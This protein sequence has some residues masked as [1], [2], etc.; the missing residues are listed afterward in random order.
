MD[1]ADDADRLQTLLYSAYDSDTVREMER[2]LLDD[3]VPL[4]RM[5]ASA[6]AH[7]T[8]TLLD[9][10]DLAVEDARVAL[11]VGAGDNGGD[12]LYAGAELANEGAHVTAIAVGRSLHEEA[13]GA[14]V[15][16]GGR[17]LVLDPAAEIPGCTTGFSAGE[18]GER[19]QAAVEYVQGSHVIIDAMTGIGVSGALRGIAGR[20]RF[21]LGIRWRTS[22]Q[23][24]PAEQRAF[25]RP[26][27]RRGDRHA[28][29][30][31]RKTVR[32][33]DRTFLLMLR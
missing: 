3:G 13:F 30:R 18:A 23:A 15:H 17:V 12:G 20:H 33:Q 11:L 14:F 25:L 26:A 10:E 24:R 16:A 22:R 27:A 7:V 6:A 19:L 32:F 5:A 29:R 9:D 21:L 31:W 4:M 8:M 1:I 28:V 2:P